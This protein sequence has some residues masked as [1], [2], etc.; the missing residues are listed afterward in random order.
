MRHRTAPGLSSPPL[1]RAAIGLHALRRAG[2]ARLRL[3]SG[4]QPAAIDL[5]AWAGRGGFAGHALNLPLGSGGTSMCLH[6]PA[7]PPRPA[8]DRG[9]VAMGDQMRRCSVFMRY[10]ARGVS[11]PSSVDRRYHPPLRAL[12]YSV[13]F[14]TN[15]RGRGSDAL[16]RDTPRHG[17]RGVAY[18]DVLAAC[19]GARASDPRPARINRNAA[20][21]EGRHQPTKTKTGTLAGTRFSDSGF[22]AGIRLRRPR[23]P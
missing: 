19:P 3:D 15:C 13:R 11:R 8:L 16:R 7:N 12:D 22:S 20:F 6:G 21:R 10:R 4:E 2:L 5:R 1:R 14:A 18:M 17:C 23:S 9:S